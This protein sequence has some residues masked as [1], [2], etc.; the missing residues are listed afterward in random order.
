[1]KRSET[2]T[3]DII[4]L[5]ASKSTLPMLLEPLQVIPH[6]ASSDGR[7]ETAMASTGTA[8]ASLYV[9][10]VLWVGSMG[11]ARTE[12]LRTLEGI[13][14]IPRLRGCTERPRRGLARGRASQQR[15][16]WPALDGTL[17]HLVSARLFAGRG[18]PIHEG[19]DLY[20]EVTL[21]LA[22]AEHRDNS[23]SVLNSSVLIA[24]L[25]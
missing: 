18:R 2:T 24:A 16:C 14:A 1:M 20:P 23:T 17:E 5:A 4:L 6:I 13:C 11:S 25:L 12:G 8:A 7:M 15:W 21:R 9:S 19:A 22:E 10:T 3:P